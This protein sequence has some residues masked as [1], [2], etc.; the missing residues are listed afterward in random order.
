MNLNTLLKKSKERI[1]QNLIFANKKPIDDTTFAIIE[2][3]ALEGVL[4][5]LNAKK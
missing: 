3:K 2:K 1:N 4:Q 5:N